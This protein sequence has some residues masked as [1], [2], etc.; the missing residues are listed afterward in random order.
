MK[1]GGSKLILGYWNMRGAGRGNP[2]R[3]LLSYAGAEWEDK[4]YTFG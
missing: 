3:Y 2:A 1:S 4:Q